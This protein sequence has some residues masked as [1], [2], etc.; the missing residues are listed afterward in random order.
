MYTELHTPKPF[1]RLRQALGLAALG[2][3]AWHLPLVWKRLSWA[4]RCELVCPP[5]LP[6]DMIELHRRSVDWQTPLLHALWP[7]A[8]VGAAGV[9]AGL[10]RRRRDAI[11]W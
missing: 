4:W 5:F 10:W 3:A 6:A 8:L 11:R 7:L 9:I 1:G 2:W